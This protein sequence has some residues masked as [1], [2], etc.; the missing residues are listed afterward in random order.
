ML[1]VAVGLA[2][3]VVVACCVARSHTLFLCLQHPGRTTSSSRPPRAAG[4]P[5]SHHHLHTNIIPAPSCCMQ[6]QAHHPVVSSASGFSKDELLRLLN[7]AHRWLPRFAGQGT[8]ELPACLCAYMCAC[9]RTPHGVWR[10]HVLCCH[11]RP[12]ISDCS[13]HAARWEACWVNGTPRVPACR[14]G[15]AGGSMHGVCMKSS[16]RSVIV[17]GHIHSARSPRTAAGIAL[18]QPP[19]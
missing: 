10:Q 12:N 3:C 17:I 11:H 16:F 5:S 6:L 2:C 15:V 13:V 9:I 19:A 4:T 8:V 7:E 14:Y 18:T 1:V